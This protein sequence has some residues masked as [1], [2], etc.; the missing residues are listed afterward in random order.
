MNNNRIYNNLK[1]MKKL[2][3]RNSLNKLINNKKIKLKKN[4]KVLINNQK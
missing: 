2:I 1:F 3:N 4:N